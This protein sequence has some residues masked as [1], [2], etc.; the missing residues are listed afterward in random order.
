MEFFTSWY[1]CA[2]LW[3]NGRGSILCT[4]SLTHSLTHTHTHTHTYACTHACM[5]TNT[6]HTHTHTH[7]HN[8][9]GCHQ[10]GKGIWWI[11]TKEKETIHVALLLFFHMSHVIMYIHASRCDVTHIWGNCYKMTRSGAY[12]YHCMPLHCIFLWYDNY[13]EEHKIWNVY[14]EHCSCHSMYTCA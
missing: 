13:V 12:Y 1:S 10:K 6:Q 7:S 8:F 9:N 4:H 2:L 3:C 11:W 14:S 5:H